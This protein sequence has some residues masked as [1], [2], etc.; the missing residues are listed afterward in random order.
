[1]GGILTH[2][3]VFPR[4]NVNVKNELYLFF[5]SSHRS[6]GWRFGLQSVTSV[7]T[8]LFFLGLFYR[9][10]SLYHPQRRAILHLKVNVFKII[11]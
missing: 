11:C 10:A 7:L 1:M 3:L 5:S 4:E 2:C 6:L 9:S 8:S